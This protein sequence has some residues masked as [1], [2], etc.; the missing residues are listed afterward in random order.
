MRKI[1]GNKNMCIYKKDVRKRQ[2]VIKCWQKMVWEERYRGGG[3]R[4]GGGGQ[5]D[6]YKSK[7]KNSI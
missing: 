7:K 3:K 2:C 4:G 5:Y 1:V 6:R